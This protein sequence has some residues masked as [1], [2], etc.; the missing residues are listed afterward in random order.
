MQV[1]ERKL[2]TKSAGRFAFAATR[3]AERQNNENASCYS[4]AERAAANTA[5][6]LLDL[7]YAYKGLHINYRKTF[8][9]VKVDGPIARDKQTV[10]AV[11]ETFAEKGYE[12]LV[13]KQGIIVRIKRTK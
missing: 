7:A 5:R 11:K 10:R 2:N 13:S 12:V 9:A 4:S 3:D 8:I 6:D 1:E